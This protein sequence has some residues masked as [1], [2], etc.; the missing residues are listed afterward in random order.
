MI[1]LTESGIGNIRI[2][3]DVL[4]KQKT[5]LIHYVGTREKAYN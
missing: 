5:I 2:V 1:T 3:Y 4:W